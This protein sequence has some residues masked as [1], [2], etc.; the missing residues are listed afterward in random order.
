MVKCAVLL[1]NSAYLYGGR[2]LPLKILKFVGIIFVIFF[3]N[4]DLLLIFLFKIKKN[5]MKPKINEIKL[6]LNN[7]PAE[8][9][10]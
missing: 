5:K 9:C 10:H 6:K 3:L 4:F 7:Y 1:S 8:R 2:E